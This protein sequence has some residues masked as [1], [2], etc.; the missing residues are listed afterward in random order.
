[1]GDAANP[2]AEGIGSSGGVLVKV[3]KSPSFEA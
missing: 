3:L 1:M 2:S